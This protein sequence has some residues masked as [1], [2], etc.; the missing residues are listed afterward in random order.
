MFVELVV[1]L[2]REKLQ[3]Y[4]DDMQINDIDLRYSIWQFVEEK[5]DLLTIDKLRS[6]ITTLAKE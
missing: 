3:E 5:K 6:L 1:Y 2:F 4:N